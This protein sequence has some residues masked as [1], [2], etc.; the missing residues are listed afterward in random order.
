MTTPWVNQHAPACPVTRH[1]ADLLSL[2]EADPKNAGLLG[3]IPEYDGGG[4]Q[5]VE[6]CTCR[7]GLVLRLQAERA[8]KWATLQ[9]QGGRGVALAN[10]IDALDEMIERV[11][12]GVPCCRFCGSE[13]IVAWYPVYER[14]GIAMAKAEDGSISFDYTG[15][16]MDTADDAGEDD[17]YRCLECDASSRDLDYLVGARDEELITHGSD[18]AIR[19]IG[20]MLDGHEWTS[21]ADY[22]EAIADTVRATGRQ[23]RPPL[24]E[25]SPD[26]LRAEWRRI[27]AG[28]TYPTVAR[29]EIEAELANRSEGTW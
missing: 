15:E 21:A 10:E 13:R 23:V 3:A 5:E 28:P 20:D 25:W 7:P 11:E 2:L 14:Q 16:D 12:S 9:E 17:E 1:R 19:A 8:G 27:I 22:L 18:T 4:D 29:D 26:E 24:T 6:N